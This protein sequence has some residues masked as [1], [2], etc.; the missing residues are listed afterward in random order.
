MEFD[1]WL[2]QAWDEHATHAAG[3]AARIGTEGL[4]LARTDA[5]A[6]ALVR[7]AHHLYGDHLGRWS[8]GR[9][10]IFH[11]GTSEPA[12]PITGT[13][14]RILDA[15]LAL[16]GGLEDLRL[17]MDASDRIRV[18]SHAAAALASHD[19]PRASSLL[20]EAALGVDTAALP[21][22][23]PA[24]RAI[25]ING[26]D[27][28]M[29][30]GDKLSRSD[31]ESDLMLLA[32]RYARDYWARAGTWLE[33]QRAEYRLAVC[34][35]KAPDVAAARRH[36]RKCLDLLREH[37]A[38]PLEWFFGW[39][40]LAL[41]ERASGNLIAQRQAVAHMKAAFAEL[42]ETERG[43]CQQNLVRAGG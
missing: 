28:A 40:A 15:S 35:L 42:E 21:H 38:P 14:Q 12:G 43:W 17:P 26:N 33:V 36:A 7:L 6:A 3:L 4:P 37:A 16:A 22:S 29:T 19:A 18:G 11:I 5:Q 31:A 39:E 8:E 23:D 10:L 34:W 13:A 30:L 9:Q 41:V 20:R 2:N 25:A 24:C 32:A 27:I 1:A